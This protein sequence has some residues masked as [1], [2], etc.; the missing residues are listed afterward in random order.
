MQHKTKYS[1]LLVIHVSKAN[2]QKKAKDKVSE[3][4]Y[5]KGTTC[6]CDSN[7]KSY[8][9]STNSCICGSSFIDINGIC[10]ACP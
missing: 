5:S 2:V 10:V 1:I 6:I 9:K 3:S 4:L 7:E 8:D